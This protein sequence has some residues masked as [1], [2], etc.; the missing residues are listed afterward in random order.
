MST[1]QQSGSMHSR[2]TPEGT[3]EHTA[4]SNSENPQSAMTDSAISKGATSNGTG[5]SR[6]TSH[7]G[8]GHHDHAA[9]ADLDTADGRKRVAIACVITAVFTVVEAVGGIISGSLALLADAAHMLTDSASLALAWIGYWFAAKA[10][11]ETHSFGFGR[12]RVLAAFIN[13]I[14]LLALAVWIMVEGAL[15]LLNPQPVIG[16]TMLIV[17]IGGLVVN[18]IAA[19]VLHGGDNDDI[20]LCGAL[21]LVLGDLLGSVAAIA[22]ALVI[23]MT[24]WTPIDPLLSILV[25]LLVFV[26]GVRITQRAGHILLQGAPDGLTPAVIRNTLIDKF[27]E[28]KKVQPVHVWQLTE[29]RLVATVCITAHAGTCTETLRLSAR[30]YLEEEFHLHLVTVEVIAEPQAGNVVMPDDSS[31]NDSNL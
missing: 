19:F 26:A 3:C 23:M 16:V 2:N 21:W 11:D 10:P 6:D 24:N 5:H 29:D 27:S 15:R 1:S 9:H 14:A 7:S 31:A 22:A 25:S 12:M 8:S 20:N 18:L 28:V 17:A 13:G 30:Q 4:W